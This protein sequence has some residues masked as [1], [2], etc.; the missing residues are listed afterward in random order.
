MTKEEMEAAWLASDIK[1][2]EAKLRWE[3]ASELGKLW[4]AENGQKIIPSSS[5]T[6][7][8]V[9]KDLELHDAK[10]AF[11][12]TELKNAVEAEKIR[13]DKIAKYLGV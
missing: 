5:K 7:D 1:A 11:L 2:N 13:N 12:V 8:D 9:L 4:I 10:R 3:R 6:V